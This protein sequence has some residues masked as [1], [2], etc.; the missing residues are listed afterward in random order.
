M[1]AIL[2]ATYYHGNISILSYKFTATGYID[3]LRLTFESYCVCADQMEHFLTT[4]Y[5]S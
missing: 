2:L 4:A 5:I 1:C 3:T